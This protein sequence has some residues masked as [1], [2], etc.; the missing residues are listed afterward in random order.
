[1]TQT[2]P[3][4]H[5][6]VFAIAPE[7][8]DAAA[9]Y[10]RAL[11]FE[12]V[13]FEHAEL[14]LRIHLD[15]D[16]GIELIAPTAD[17]PSGPGTAKEFLS[18]NGDGVFSVVVR[19][20]DC[21]SAERSAQRHGTSADFRQHVEADGFVVDEVKMQPLYGIPLTFMTANLPGDTAGDPS[22]APA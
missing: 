5:H 12:F 3:N 11:G 22:A 21:D 13:S 7:R 2:D 9:D 20:P 16:R 15:W 14:H 19:V 1:M 6:V 17:A 18:R 10:L 8:L 4:L